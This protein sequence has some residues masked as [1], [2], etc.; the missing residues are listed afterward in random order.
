MMNTWFSA[1]IAAHD[2]FKRKYQKPCATG[3]MLDF[4]DAMGIEL[5]PA[6]GDFVLIN[7]A[8]DS[9]TRVSRPKFYIVAP[10]VCYSPLL[11]HDALSYIRPFLH[12]LALLR[13]S[14]S[15]LPHQKWQQW[16]R[17]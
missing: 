1:R 7:E 5:A 11:L 15:D 16:T 9:L 13:F 4:L 10:L 17:N 12:C 8:Y 2:N 3:E 6:D 14:C